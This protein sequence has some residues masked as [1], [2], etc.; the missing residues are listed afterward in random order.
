MIPEKSIQLKIVLIID[1][2]ILPPHSRR[3]P[4]KE[5]AKKCEP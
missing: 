3:H 2:P 1:A 5:K 4:S